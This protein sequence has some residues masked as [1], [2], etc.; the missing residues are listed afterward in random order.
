MARRMESIDVTVTNYALRFATAIRW[1]SRVNCQLRC[2]MREPLPALGRPRRHDSRAPNLR[3]RYHSLRS[4]RVV[5]LK[6]IRSICVSL[7]KWRTRRQHRPRAEH[8]G[9]K[10]FSVHQT[11]N[12]GAALLEASRD[13]VGAR[14][15]NADVYRK[16][17]SILSVVLAISTTFAVF[18]GVGAPT[19]ALR[20]AE[21]HRF[22]KRHPCVSQRFL[23]A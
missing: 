13:E 17:S 2:M 20:E 15:P 6:T 23:A 14:F 4:A 9:A 22:E 11:G 12:D 16:E 21:P 3:R 8:D 18:P 19:S 1:R 5:F 7:L 10:W